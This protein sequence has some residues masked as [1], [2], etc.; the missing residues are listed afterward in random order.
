MEAPASKI[1]ERMP[2]NYI[3]SLWTSRMFKFPAGYVALIEPRRRV[4]LYHPNRSILNQI[5]HFD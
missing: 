4:K 3:F 2:L 5:N 1:G